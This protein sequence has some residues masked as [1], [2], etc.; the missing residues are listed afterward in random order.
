VSGAPGAGSPLRVWAHREAVYVTCTGA[1]LLGR[2]ADL[3]EGA[4]AAGGGGGGGWSDGA[5]LADVEKSI[6]M[7]MASGGALQDVQRIIRRARE[8]NRSLSADEHRQI[9]ELSGMGRQQQAAAGVPR[10]SHHS[11]L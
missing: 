9:R 10:S 7:S 4:T 5:S 6:G 1:S 2:Q 11:I 8:E 3:L